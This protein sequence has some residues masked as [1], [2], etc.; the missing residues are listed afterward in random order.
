VVA[1]ASVA[2]AQLTTFAPDTPARAALVNAN[3][4]QLVTWIQQKV[5]TVGSP[6]VSVTGTTTLGST[7]SVAGATTL[8]STTTLNGA[9]AAMSTVRVQ[10]GTTSNATAASGRGL[11]VSAA[12]SAADAPILEVRHDNLTQGIGIGYNTIKATGSN[13]N[14]ELQLQALGTSSI[15]LLSPVRFSSTVSFATNRTVTEVGTNGGG[16]W[17]TAANPSYCG[18]GQYVCGVRLYTEPDQGGGDDTALN[19]INL[20]CCTLGN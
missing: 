15:N 9:T 6:N 2:L 1:G 12:T 7:L 3:F 4:Q 5:G 16:S 11:F 17:G 14:Q 19:D 10:T 13:P 8:G 20:M 18:A